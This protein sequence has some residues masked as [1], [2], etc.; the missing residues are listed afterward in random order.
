[1]IKHIVMFRIKGEGEIKKKNTLFFKDNL[2]ALKNKIPEAN[3]LETGMNFSES[4]SAFDLVL[5]THFDLASDLEIYKKHPDHQK[6]AGLMKEIVNEVA[7]V[8]FNTSN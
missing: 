7:V 1:M 4:P 3:Y 5:T 2:D 6:I 8:D